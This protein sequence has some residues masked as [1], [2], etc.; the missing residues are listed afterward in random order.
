M[1]TWKTIDALANDQRISVRTAYRWLRS[2]KVR[3]MKDT[4]GEAVFFLTSDSTGYT[5]MSAADVSRVS[6]TDKQH[7]SGERKRDYETPSR[8]KLAGRTRSMPRERREE[9]DIEIDHLE[10]RH[11]A[12]HEERQQ[13][14]EQRRAW[15]K[16]WTEW[17]VTSGVPCGA[18][19]PAIIEFQIRDA[20]ELALAKRSMEDDERAIRELVEEI[21]TSIAQKY[22]YEQKKRKDAE[23]DRQK[24]ERKVLETKRRETN[25]AQ[26]IKTAPSEVD[27][28]IKKHDFTPYVNEVMRMQIREELGRKLAQTLTGE[29]FC[30][31]V[32]LLEEILDSLFEE[33]KDKAERMQKAKAEAEERER[34]KKIAQENRV[35]LI[36][37]GIKRLNHYLSANQRELG[38]IDSSER[39]EAEHYL[40]DELEEE[41]EGTESALEVESL[42]DEILEEFFFPQEDEDG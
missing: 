21:A 30:V 24:E 20:V 22:L 15:I 23:A 1:G 14:T 4:Q 8:K 27:T 26:L 39:K 28:Y 36:L 41:I 35:L 5:D 17:A 9:R 29:E 2:G 40:E 13:R 7:H 18:S 3:K 25:K 19:L 16:K 38:T 31:P 37:V 12:E 10:D 6:L 32:N 42:A 34:Q 33:T 11:K